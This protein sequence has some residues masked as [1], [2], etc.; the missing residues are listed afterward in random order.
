MERRR[1]P[2]VALGMLWVAALI[3]FGPMLLEPN[4]DTEA[5]TELPLGPGDPEGLPN[6]RRVTANLYRG[7]QP[8]TAGFRYLK[9]IGVR[10]VV[11]LRHYH[12]DRYMLEK[13]GGL[14]YEPIN[15]KAWS[16]YIGHPARFLRIATDQRYTPVFVH[17]NDGIGRTGVLCAMYRIIVCGWSKE[18][19]LREFNEIAQ[20]DP[21]KDHPMRMKIMQKLLE[22]LDDL[23][24]EA[25]RRQAGL[26]E[27][28]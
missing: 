24:A 20:A 5:E 16:V 11:N 25:V 21:N 18:E 4:E 3:Y 17:C 22:R 27:Q 8:T 15:I 14:A 6:F 10:T 1:I 26:A 19:A 23:D 7:A 28:Q 13:V 9:R 12:S 2:T